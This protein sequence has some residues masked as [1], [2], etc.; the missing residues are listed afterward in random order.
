MDNVVRARV[1]LT[2]MDAFGE[3]NEVY[4]DFFSEPYPARTA[5]R[6]EMASSEIKV[7]IDVTAALE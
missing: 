6:A 2:D 3:L 4:E 1:F 5:V 7:E